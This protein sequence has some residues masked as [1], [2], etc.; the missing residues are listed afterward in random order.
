MFCPQ[1]RPAHASVIARGKVPSMICL[2]LPRGHTFGWGVR[3]KYLTRGLAR[4]SRVVVLTEPITSDYTGD[5]PEDLFRKGVSAPP[6][7]SI[8]T[9]Q[10]P[11]PHPSHL[12]LAHYHL[13]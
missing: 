4:L 13:S 10:R 6:C 8:D 5:D 2:V 11:R 3:G 9:T 1:S 7:D 12:A